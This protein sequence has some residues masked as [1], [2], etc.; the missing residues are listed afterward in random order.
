VKDSEGLRLKAYLCPAGVWTVGYGSTGHHVKPGTTVTTAEA[1]G[2]LRADLRRFE[3]A[4]E[5]AAARSTDNQFSAMVSLAFNIGIGAFEKSTVL[6]LHHK[7]DHKG[8]AAAFGM[9]TKATV[10]GRKV[11]LPG[12]VT[13]RAKEAS[14]Y[15]RKD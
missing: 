9:W 2:L 11:T 14:L 4:V 6:R 15:L 12:L 3:G 10:R 7:G 5:R 8:A 13:R 1:E